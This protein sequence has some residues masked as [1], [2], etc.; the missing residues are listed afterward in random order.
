MRVRCVSW[1]NGKFIAGCIRARTFYSRSSLGGVF[2]FCGCRLFACAP[3]ESDG[4]RTEVCF[5]LKFARKNRLMLTRGKRESGS[6]FIILLCWQLFCRCENHSRRC[7][8]NVSKD[9]FV[10]FNISFEITK[11]WVL[12][13]CQKT[14]RSK[15][16]SF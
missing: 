1:R 16:F 3:V 15:L 7:G 10:S 12:I 2:F 14:K 6:A 4:V 9:T 13:Q 11:A 5:V 8:K